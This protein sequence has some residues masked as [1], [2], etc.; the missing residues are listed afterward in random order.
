MKSQHTEEAVRQLSKFLDEKSVVI[1][2]QNGLNEYAISKMI[3]PQRTVGAF[4]NWAADYIG[5]GYIKLGGK[6]SFYLGEV[7]GEMSARIMNLARPLSA[8]FPV[9]FT[10]NIMGYLWSKQVDATVWFATALADM[11]IHE[12]VETP[13]DGQRDG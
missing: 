12:V 9:N 7:N 4:I 5:P 13:R 6:G 11:P 1:S 8:L 3:G 2:L 10:A